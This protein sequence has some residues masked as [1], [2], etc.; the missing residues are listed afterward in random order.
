[1]GWLT[2]PIIKNKFLRIAIG[3]GAIAIV[4]GALSS[5]AKLPDLTIKLDDL[6]SAFD[7][8]RKKRSDAPR[9]TLDKCDTKEKDRRVCLYQIG[10]GMTIIA[11]ANDGEILS[12]VELIAPI[13]SVSKLDG[14]LKWFSAVLAAMELFSQDAPQQEG[15]DV[16]GKLTEAW[17]GQ[18]GERS[19]R[20][21][22]I[23]YRLGDDDKKAWRLY[24][25]PMLPP[26]GGS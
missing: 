1:M 22:R 19:A 16:I 23:L 26:N 8:V 2:T 17:T 6:P 20:L 5:K 13:S 24:V 15:V 11:A 18:G 12:D 3:L 9:L 10:N 14:K 25:I 4:I 21:G 7:G